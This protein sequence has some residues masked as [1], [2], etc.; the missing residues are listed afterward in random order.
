MQL[1][2]VSI[3]I[4]ENN[5]SFENFYHGTFAGFKACKTPKRKPDY[6]SYDRY[7]DISS[8]YWYG[9]D[10]N[11]S[12]VI[13]SSSHWCLYAHRK[14]VNKARAG[15]CRRIANNYWYFFTNKIDITTH[16]QHL[17]FRSQITV[18]T[19]TDCGKVYLKNMVF[20]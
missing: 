12:Y 16:T 8:K 13:R 14:D 10:K 19:Q 15:E 5:I 6:I 11:G 9:T 1:K 3:S 4:M 7:G 20:I 2:R 17:S 18:F